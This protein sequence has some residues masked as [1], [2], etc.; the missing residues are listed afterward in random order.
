MN[1]LIKEIKLNIYFFIKNYAGI[2][3]FYYYGTLII[4]QLITTL[5]FN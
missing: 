4:L 5:L 3:S 2:S 1:V